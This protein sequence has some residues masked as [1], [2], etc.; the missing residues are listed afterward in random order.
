[1][2]AEEKQNY[3][4][5]DLNCVLKTFYSRLKLQELLDWHLLS[6]SV[7]EE[8]AVSSE[9]FS[10]LKEMHIKNQEKEENL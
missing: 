7:V 4:D 2:L 9:S 10:S 3:A 8:D 6:C 5:M 1:M